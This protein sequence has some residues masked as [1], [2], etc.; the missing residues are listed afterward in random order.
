MGSYQALV[1]DKQAA[2]SSR[3]ASMILSCREISLRVRD[4]RRLV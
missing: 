2:R 4:L 3:S 1:A